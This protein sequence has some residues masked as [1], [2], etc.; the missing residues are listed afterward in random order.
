MAALLETTPL[1]AWPAVARCLTGADLFDL[2]RASKWSWQLFS[3]D[4]YWRDRLSPEDT[5]SHDDGASTALQLYLRAYSFQFQG[6][7]KVAETDAAAAAATDLRTT[8]GSCAQV[9]SY[10]EEFVRQ[11]A[12]FAFDMWF[13]LL[14]GDGSA[15]HTGG[16]L[17]GAQ[18]VSYENTWWADFHQQ[19]AI[20]SSDRKLYCSVVDEKPEIAA[21]LEL[22]RWYHLALTHGNQTQRV[23]LDGELVSTLSG[24]LHREWWQ[25]YHAQAGTGCITAGE[26]N[27]P[28]PQ[29]CGW[30]PFNGLINE[31]R[32]WKREL[33]AEDVQALAYGN[34]GLVQGQPHYSMRTSVLFYPPK[35]TTRVGCSRPREKIVERLSRHRSAPTST[36]PP[37]TAAS[38]ADR[39]QW[40]RNRRV[41]RPGGRSRG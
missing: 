23:Y 29:S 25:L 13:C 31:F 39:D 38:R 18:S 37:Q 8:R 16:I 33:S 4:A 9:P 40:Q 35:H 3:Q 5:H 26:R 2:A 10:H 28:E 19:L 11:R 21:N 27:F 6:L 30:Y 20:V 12:P 15:M 32:M 41:I 34:A 17:F 1:D 14:D 22:K 7:H 36:A 24:D